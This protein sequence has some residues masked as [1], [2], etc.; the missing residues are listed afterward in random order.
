[1]TAVNKMLIR[2]MPPILVSKDQGVSAT[3]DMISSTVA[4]MRRNLE[5]GKKDPDNIVWG[6][7]LTVISPFGDGGGG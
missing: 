2:A 5:M 6:D 7:E 1:M 3:I 4:E